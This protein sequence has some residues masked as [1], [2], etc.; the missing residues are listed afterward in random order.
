MAGTLSRMA[1]V[2]VVHWRPE[3]VRG[4]IERLRSV[5]EVRVES[6]Q[7][8][9]WHRAL[10]DDPAHVIVIDLSRLPS[11]G[12]EIATYLRTQKATR[13][14]PLVFVGGEE[15]KVAEAKTIFP[16]ARFCAWR[17]L[18]GTITRALDRPAR[19]VVPGNFAGYSGTPLPQKLGVKEG[20][21]LALL[22]APEGFAGTMGP[23]PER[24]RIVTS[25]RGKVD[26]AVLFAE[27]LDDLRRRWPA[28]ARAAGERGRLWVAWPKKASG[29]RTDLSEPV[30]RE[31]GLGQGLVDFKVCAI[32]GTW[33]GLAFT[34]RKR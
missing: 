18:R 19:Q 25:A 15:S 5:H 8:G 27:S 2:L 10:R 29:V 6:R 16:D 3:E 1:K 22:G 21:T 7:D 28:A 11:H 34:T 23:L 31:H 32:D 33:S 4:Q 9:D 12:R 26:V 24:V 20:S 13:D 14:L 30:V 17:T